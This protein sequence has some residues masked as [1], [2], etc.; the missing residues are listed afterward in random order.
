MNIYIDDKSF[1]DGLDVWSYHI[2]LMQ[3]EWDIEVDEEIDTRA[4]EILR[5]HGVMVIEDNE[6]E[7]LS[8]EEKEEDN[9]EF[10]KIMYSQFEDFMLEHISFILTKSINLSDDSYYY[11]CFDMIA[12]HM[13]ETTLEKLYQWKNTA[14]NHKHIVEETSKTIFSYFESNILDRNY[15]MHITN[16]TYYKKQ[17]DNVINYFLNSIINRIEECNEGK[18]YELYK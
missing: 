4:E 11:I 18:R 2:D 9:R 16:M 1:T 17:W 5:N 7:K 14:L 8:D 3:K 10:L 15:K 12:R 13:G 6:Y